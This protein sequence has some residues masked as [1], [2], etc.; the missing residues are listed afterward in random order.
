MLSVNFLTSHIF[1]FFKWQLFP[2]TGIIISQTEDMPATKI[3][4]GNLTLELLHLELFKN[5]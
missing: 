4:S 3:P 5:K 2:F 1:T